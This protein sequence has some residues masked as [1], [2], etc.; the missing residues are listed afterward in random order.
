MPRFT[1]NQLR[2]GLHRYLERRRSRRQLATLDDRLL[3][4]VGISRAQVRRESRRL[5]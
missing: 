3:R 1:L 5:F 2:A 4:D